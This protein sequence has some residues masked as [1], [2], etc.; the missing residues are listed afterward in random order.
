MARRIRI[1]VAS[2]LLIP[3]AAILDAAVELGK[4][5]IRSEESKNAFHSM[6]NICRSAEN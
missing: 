6:R 3:D 5:P 2:L 4:P 1:I